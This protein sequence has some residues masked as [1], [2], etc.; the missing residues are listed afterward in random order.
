MA[1]TCKCE[2]CGATISTNNK[3]CPNCGA[4]NPLYVV[5]E[6]RIITDPQTIEEL[7][8][9]C[10]ER[11]MPLARM[12]FF[13]GV[14]FKDPKAFGIYRAPDGDV[15]VYK[16]KADGT[17]AIRY[18][19]RDE[20]HAVNE[21]YGKLL[22]ECHNRGIYPDGK[23]STPYMSNSNSRESYYTRSNRTNASN[24]F[25]NSIISNFSR[26]SSD[27]ARK[28]C[29][30]SSVAI[31][32]WI[33][34]MAFCFIFMNVKMSEARNH[35]SGYYKYNDDMYFRQGNNWYYYDDAIN[36]WYEVDNSITDSM[37]DAN[38]DYYYEGSWNSDWGSSF[39]NSDAY[40]EYQESRSSSSSD[41]DWDSGSSDSSW[42]DWDSGST[43]WDSDW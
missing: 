25:A 22:E 39:Y 15:V 17:R 35:P 31:L 30:S 41:N 16:N 13:I 36:D 29:R 5:D 9:Y 28:G 38:K 32:V 8:E 11:G 7:Q 33:S 40:R 2:Y 21:I 6:E 4:S 18:K 19:G 1:S 42:D 37:Y 14:D 10:A 26:N 20:R 27:A 23:S 43:D 12:R 24:S 3:M 34:I